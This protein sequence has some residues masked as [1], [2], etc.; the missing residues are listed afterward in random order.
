MNLRLEQ[1][2]KRYPGA[3][4]LALDGVSLE[5]ACEAEQCVGMACEELS[6]GQRVAIAR[7]PISEPRLLI[8]D[9]PTS[10][11]SRI[12]REAIMAQLGRHRAGRHAGARC[13]AR[14]R[15]AR[16]AGGAG[17]ELGA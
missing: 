11:L 12:E 2:C 7:A 16:R 4:R 9:G 10:R 13:P 14:A 5:L 15:Q 17:S 1:V 8:A 6:E 3:E